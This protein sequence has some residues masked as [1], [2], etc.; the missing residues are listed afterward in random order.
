[1]FSQHGLLTLLSLSFFSLSLTVQ[2]PLQDDPLRTI[3]SELGPPP[4]SNTQELNTARDSEITFELASRMT[5]LKG[6]LRLGRL[7]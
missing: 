6:E 1:M 7:Q 2:A 3:L 5:T 4:V